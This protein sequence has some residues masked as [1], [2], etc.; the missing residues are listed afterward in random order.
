MDHGWLMRMIGHRIADPRLLRLVEQWL[1]VGVREKGECHEMTLGTPQG[2][3]ISP[4]LANVYL[5]YVLELWVQ[6]RD[7]GTRQAK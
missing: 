6:P 5:H 2:A 3:G 7:D 1:R 4:L